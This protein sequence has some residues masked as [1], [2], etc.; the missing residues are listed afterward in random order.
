MAKII[1]L[2]SE[3]QPPIE[4]GLVPDIRYRVQV[5]LQHPK[6]ELFLC[7]HEHYGTTF[8]GGWLEEGENFQDASYREITE[9][10]GYLN[11]KWF[12]NLGLEIHLLRKHESKEANLQTISQVTYCKLSD[13]EQEKAEFDFQWVEKEKVS[14]T[15]NFKVSELAWEHFLNGDN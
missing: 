7:L 9:E 11:I 5:I 10:T 12:R 14:E 3:T 1:K 8:I 15:L 2:I 13:L 4:D 6:E